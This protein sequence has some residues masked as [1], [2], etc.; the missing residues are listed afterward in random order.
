MLLRQVHGRRVLDVQPRQV[1]T[2]AGVADAATTAAEDVVLGV[3]VADCVPVLLASG[4]RIGVAH[5]GRI[6]L[7]EGVVEAVLRDFASPGRAAIGPSIRGCCY[8]VPEELQQE[9]ARRRPAAAATTTWGTPSLDLAAAAR[10]VLERAGWDVVDVDVCTHHDDRFMSHRRD[11][12]TGRQAG[13]VRRTR[14]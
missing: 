8:E 11:P 14:P 13:L 4:R 9:V 10:V 1:G 7:H 12:A 3:L 5:A 6:G 2:E